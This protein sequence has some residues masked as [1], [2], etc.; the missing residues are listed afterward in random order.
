VESESDANVIDCLIFVEPGWV[1]VPPV[2]VVVV[3][4]DDV[5]PPPELYP[6]PEV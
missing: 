6:D 1:V 2:V 3:V 4:V 5:V